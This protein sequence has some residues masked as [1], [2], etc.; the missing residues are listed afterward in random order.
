MAT[1]PGSNEGDDPPPSEADV[2]KRGEDNAG[3]EERTAD[4]PLIVEVE[5]DPD[6]LTKRSRKQEESLRRLQG[7]LRDWP[8]QY[9]EPDRAAGALMLALLTKPKSWVHRRVENVEFSEVSRVRRRVS[10]DF[11]ILEEYYK[12]F[13][14]EYKDL[15]TP[16]PLTLLRKRLLA[17]FDVSNA[18]GESVPMLNKLQNGHLAWSVLVALSEIALSDGS[19]SK[20]STISNELQEQ[21]QKNSGRFKGGCRRSP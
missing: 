14:I 17:G 18:S 15:P 9:T 8:D 19:D 1:L 7:R 6:P 20:P 16:L 12:A 3:V 11:T 4:V 21:L 2:H 5:L 10:V 13:D